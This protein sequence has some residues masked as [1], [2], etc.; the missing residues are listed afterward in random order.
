MC[1]GNSPEYLKKYV[2]RNSSKRD[3]VLRANDNL[4]ICNLLRHTSQNSLIYMGF[5][6]YNSLTI[7]IKNAST[8]N[9]FDDL[10][11]LWIKSNIQ[12]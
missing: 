12:I 7:G 10:L 3:Y 11:K 4:A 2:I 9:K 1:H 6:L 5:K 8:P